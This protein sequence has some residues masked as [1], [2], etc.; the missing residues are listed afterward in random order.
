MLKRH[1]GKNNPP[2]PCLEELKDVAQYEWYQILQ[3][4]IQNLIFVMTLWMQEVIRM[5]IGLA[6]L[7]LYAISIEQ[8]KVVFFF[9]PELT[10]F[11]FRLVTRTLYEWGIKKL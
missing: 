4:D 1:I 7:W 5:S 11:Y 9:K 10:L 6:K 2:P 8:Q 3:E